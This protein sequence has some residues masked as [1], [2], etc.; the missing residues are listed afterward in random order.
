VFVVLI[1][2]ACLIF[3]GHAYLTKENLV[4]AVVGMLTLIGL[5]RVLTHETKCATKEF[6]PSL[7]EMC[8][9]YYAFRRRLRELQSEFRGAPRLDGEPAPAGTPGRGYEPASRPG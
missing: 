1:A 4:I 3:F 9:G 6:F 5:L 8:E 7:T 2:F